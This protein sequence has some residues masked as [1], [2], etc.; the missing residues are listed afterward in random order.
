MI[1]LLRQPC[2]LIAVLAPGLWTQESV[3]AIL[4]S[5]AEVRGLE[6]RLEDIADVGG[7]E[8]KD[9]ASVRRLRLGQ[10]PLPGQRKLLSK[11]TIERLLRAGPASVKVAI[12]GAKSVSL[13]SATVT[14]QPSE[15]EALALREVH[16]ALGDEAKNATV[17]IS[18]R[19]APLEVP[20]GRYRNRFEF[21]MPERTDL[22]GLVRL[23]LLA[24]ADDTTC[25]HTHVDVVIEREVSFLVAKEA[26]PAGKPVS[27]SQVAMERRTAGFASK[28]ALK[29]DQDLD[30]AILKTRI[31]AGG[32][33]HKFD[34]QPR[35]LV[36]RNDPVA[37][38]V[39]SGNLTVTGEGVALADGG[40]GEL[41]P[42][43]SNPGRQVLRAAILDSKTVEVSLERTGNP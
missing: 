21:A 5:S 41:I 22:A 3:W 26:L 11:E 28:G 38:R 16:R 43:R 35:R 34:L 33:I 9:V 18:V 8:P 30:G 15:L 31:P 37:I 24:T 1:R 29:S 17:S 7:L 4:K 10:A 12:R 2:L 19:P 39:R 6:V 32:T 40:L 14:V 27:K 36:S 25:A 42:V 23:Q 20:A 13:S